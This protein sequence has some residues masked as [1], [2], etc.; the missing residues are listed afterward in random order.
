MSWV[1][2]TF[3][4]LALVGLLGWL[5]AAPVAA[6]ELEL[7][8]VAMLSEGSL[9]HPEADVFPT[10]EAAG[11]HAREIFYQ[12]IGPGGVVSFLA[13]GSGSFREGVWTGQ[14]G[15]FDF[16][17]RTQLESSPGRT[18][19]R[20]IAPAMSA[21]HITFYGSEV[22]GI[23]N[24]LGIWAGP[25]GT[26]PV[27][28]VTQGDAAPGGGLFTGFDEPT[29]MANGAVVFIAQTDVPAGASTDEG[30]F[31]VTPTGEVEFLIRAGV[32]SPGF[33]QGAFI[34]FF[35][36][37]A[38]GGLVYSAFTPS[39]GPRN[40]H[41]IY[42]EADPLDPDPQLVAKVDE[43]TPGADS[44]AFWFIGPQAIGEDGSVYIF[45]QDDG[46]VNTP[47]SFRAVWKWRDG[48][49]VNIVRGETTAPGTGGQNFRSLGLSPAFDGPICDAHGRIGVY[50]TDSLD[51]FGIWFGDENGVKLLALEELQ[52]PGTENSFEHLDPP[53][54]GPSGHVAFHSTMVRPD[55]GRLAGGGIF[56]ADIDGRVMKVVEEGDELFLRGKMRTVDRVALHDGQGRYA[57][58]ERPL[59]ADG[60]LVFTVLTTDQFCFLLRVQ[61]PFPE[62]GRDA[63]LIRDG[64]VTLLAVESRVGYR[65]QL[66]A[67]GDLTTWEAVGDP[68]DGTGDELLFD[69]TPPEEE[70]QRRFCRIS[71]A[72]LR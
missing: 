53:A 2:R 14:P 5:D 51:R 45:A 34:D 64:A 18:F 62:S 35:D 66:E 59:N 63:E 25:V 22:S 42:Y 60:Q 37:D 32:A 49:V 20:T 13:E 12:S 31:V 29:K 55:G 11:W 8:V 71:I 28:L 7:E 24:H 70:T 39:G 21:G 4:L 9:P 67:S 46:K 26:E 38:H 40:V 44:G 16:I 36:A 43:V 1:K 10:M 33:P 27:R 52:A 61:I 47:A 41:G 6:G 54:V 58:R 69:C 56:A 57:Y 72:P 48:R 23:G 3:K 17:A 65:Y 30:L 19:R 15:D 68:V 50:G